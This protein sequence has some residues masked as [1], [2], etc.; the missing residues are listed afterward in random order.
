MAEDKDLNAFKESQEVATVDAS[1]KVRI[2]FITIYCEDHVPK[3]T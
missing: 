2:G 1:K 3:H